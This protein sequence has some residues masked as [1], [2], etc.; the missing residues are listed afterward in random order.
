MIQE[1][2]VWLNL[3]SEGWTKS[4]QQILNE[5]SAAQLDPA[6][7]NIVFRQR[8]GVCMEFFGALDFIREWQTH[9]AWPDNQIFLR[10][11]NPV[12]H[13]GA[14]INQ[15]PEPKV[16]F[17]TQAAQ[18][19]HNYFCHSAPQ[20]FGFFVGRPTPERMRIMRDIQSLWPRQF[21]TS[22][23][24]DT[25]PSRVDLML[26][27]I[28]N[29]TPDLFDRSELGDFLS[30]YEQYQPCSLDAMTIED[31]TQLPHSRLCASLAPVYSD[32]A[33]E[34]VAETMV[35]GN[36]F[37]PTEKT[38]RPMALG[39]PFVIFGPRDYLKNLR[40]FG[41]RTF[42][43]L[44]DESYDQLEGRDRWLAMIPVIEHIC[45]NPDLV[46]SSAEIVAH[47]HALI[48]RPTVHFDWH[49]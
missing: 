33:V 46:Q 8:E 2:L 11:H 42:G 29:F 38:A 1:H 16:W 41:F 12:E 45:S 26:W 22:Q 37:F 34:L 47:N 31:Q 44:W 40:G 49:I 21:V 9:T 48:S 7:T 39:K 4:R 14:W 28:Q 18:Y 27:M 3:Y 36:C 5:I 30:W 32:F 6:Y 23:L 15:T 20:M 13:Y 24:T 17:L 19:A 35:R 43:D 10:I 25:E